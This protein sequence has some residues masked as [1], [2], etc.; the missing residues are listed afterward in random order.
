MVRKR[1]IRRLRGRRRA[2]GYVWK[3]RHDEDDKIEPMPGEIGPD[4]AR[5]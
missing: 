5:P 2:L 4:D 3:P 1:R